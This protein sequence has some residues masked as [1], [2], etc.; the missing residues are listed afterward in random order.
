LWGCNGTGG[1][2]RGGEH[3]SLAMGGVPEHPKPFGFRERNA[4]R[5]MAPREK[6]KRH[7]HQKGENGL[8]DYGGTAIKGST[9]VP[10]KLFRDK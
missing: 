3:F 5:E 8:P 9:G 2:I 6:E 1:G 4:E 10:S 7:S